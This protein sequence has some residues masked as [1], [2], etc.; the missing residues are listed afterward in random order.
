MKSIIIALLVLADVVARATIMIG[1]QTFTPA[2]GVIPDGNPVGTVF[3]GNFTWAPSGDQILGP[4]EV[5]LNVSGGYAGD[6]YAYLVD[7]KGEMVVLMN[8]PGQG[9]GTPFGN[10]SSGFNITLAAS[11]GQ[12]SFASSGQLSGT[13][14]VAGLG[15]LS[16]NATGNWELYFADLSPGGVS[17]VTSWG[18]GVTV[19]PEPVTVAL[20]VFGVLL[21]GLGTVRWARSRAV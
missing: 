13:Y 8:R 18:L 10:P 17:T 16:G 15:N 9:S 5:T 19:V 1:P 4:V 2:N 3:N 6:L 20:G 21:V 14:N 11:G 7:P 12:S